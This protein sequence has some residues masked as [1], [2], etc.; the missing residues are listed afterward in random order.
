MGRSRATSGY[1]DLGDRPHPAPRLAPRGLTTLR[2]LFVT[3]ACLGLGAAT[4]VAQVVDVSAYYLN[5]FSYSGDSPVSDSG[6]TDFQRLR[7]MWTPAVGPLTLDVGYE[8]TLQ[9]HAERVLGTGAVALVATP[10]VNWLDLDWTGKSSARSIWRHRFDRLAITTP[11][12]ESVELSVGRQ[13]VSWAS[14]LVLTP[15]DPFSPF[16]PADPFREYRAGIDAVRLRAYLGAFSEVDVVVRPTSSASLDQLTALARGKTNWRGWDVA[17]WGGVLFDDAAAAVSA[18]GALAGW[19]VRSELSVRD[20]GVGV[21]LRGT[22]GVD[23]RFAI[24]G[25]DLYVVAEYQRDEF[26]ASTSDDLFQ[27]ALSSAFLRGEQ[28]VLARDALATQA[29]YQIHPLWAADLLALTS[30]SDGSV[31]L[32]G[33]A[34]W[35]FGSNSSIR[36]GLFVGV[37]DDASAPTRI[38]SEFGLTPTVL[39]VSLTHFF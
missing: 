23:R 39:Y 17:L 38:G 12:G 36:G 27:V 28:Q 4:L 21:A 1:D 31:L 29:S 32:S 3:V 13:V 30:L 10:G 11:L 5:L 6:L 7:V 20:D 34:S 37:G 35:A 2:A 18:V 16:D 25:R 22:V 19:A 33:G 9:L 8:H 15:A 14:T 26:G 24:Y